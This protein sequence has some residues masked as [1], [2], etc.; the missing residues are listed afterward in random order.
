MILDTDPLCDMD[1]QSFISWNNIL[2][3]SSFHA[4]VKSSIQYFLH[5]I[6]FNFVVA[7]G[8]DGR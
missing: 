8:K 5:I 6:L 4:C 3:N 1:K 2:L 7:G